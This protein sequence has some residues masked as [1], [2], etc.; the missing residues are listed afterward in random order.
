MSLHR[1]QDR[2]QTAALCAALLLIAPAASA[3]DT[4]ARPRDS[5]RYQSDRAACDS[6]QSHQDRATCLREAGAAREENRRGPPGD[7]PSRYQQ[8][9]TVRCDALPAA[10]RQDC[11]KRLQGQG[12]TRG[13]VAEGG[14]YRETVTREPAPQK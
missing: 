6:G 11:L 2:G 5:S 8:N 4:E 7:D 3:A 9:A 14:I 13:S 1:L 10:D 12:T